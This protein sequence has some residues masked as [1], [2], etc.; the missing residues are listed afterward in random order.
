MST[1]LI[2]LPTLDRATALDVF[3]IPGGIEPLLMLVRA[4]IDEFPVVDPSSKKGRDAIASMAMKVTKS[5]TFLDGEG[6]KLVD[7]L[8][9]LPKA[10]DATRK[11]VRDTLDQ[12]RDEVRRPLT[13][14]EEREAARV[15]AHKAVVDHLLALGDPG[16]LLSASASSLEAQLR[17][18]GTVEIGPHLEE[19][20]VEATVAKARTVERIEAVLLQARARE[21]QAAELERMRAENADAIARLHAANAA[22]KQSAEAAEVVAETVESEP[23]AT[24]SVPEQNQPAG[25]TVAQQ[26]R[27]ARDA[28]MLAGVEQ[29]TAEHVVRL[30]RRGAV[31]GVAFV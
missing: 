3:S 19:Y 20:E 17:Q 13:E 22:A 14:W 11:H 23:A 5:K 1:D 9:A 7:E 26:N 27:A 25:P 2:E 28:L 10:V 4:A 18:A 30:I 12:W 8:K 6:K 21:E 31:P 29:A 24:Y 16:L 15:A